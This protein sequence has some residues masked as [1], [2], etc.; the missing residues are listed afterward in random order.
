MHS[1]KES[2]ALNFQIN[3]ISKKLYLLCSFTTLHYLPA[4]S[5]PAYRSSLYTR[6]SEVP[7]LIFCSSTKNLSWK[8]DVQLLWCF[9]KLRFI[10]LEQKSAGTTQRTANPDLSNSDEES[11]RSS[12]DGVLCKYKKIK[13][14][15]IHKKQKNKI[16]HKE[17]QH[18]IL[19]AASKSVQF[20]QHEQEKWQKKGGKRLKSTR[21]CLTSLFYKSCRWKTKVMLCVHI[22]KKEGEHPPGERVLHVLCGPEDVFTFIKSK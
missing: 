8:P 15:H 2:W 5:P 3:Y 10:Y 14:K 1:F 11:D 4:D 19:P 16:K 21:K 7:S 6:Q 18:S 20:T 9:H 17:K 12:N 13:T 22:L